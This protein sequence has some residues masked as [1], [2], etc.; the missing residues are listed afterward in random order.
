MTI[1]STD[2]SLCLPAHFLKRS[3]SS[4]DLLNTY[5]TNEKFSMFSNITKV[6]ERENQWHLIQRGEGGGGGSIN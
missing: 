6:H 3:V 2:L 4:E 1:G 5:R